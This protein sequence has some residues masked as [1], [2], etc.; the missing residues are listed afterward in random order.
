MQHSPMTRMWFSKLDPLST[1]RL[2][3]NPY[4]LQGQRPETWLES[5][6]L[7]LGPIPQL[8]KHIPFTLSCC[9]LAKQA[10]SSPSTELW[11]I[12]RIRRPSLNGQSCPTSP[13]LPLKVQSQVWVGIMG[14][15]DIE[16]WSPDQT[17][18]SHVTSTTLFISPLSRFSQL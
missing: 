16:V 10:E 13:H 14:A 18:G 4:H 3:S 7:A 5:Q 12:M 6:G 11:E 8:T 15:P 1:D 17:A 9:F 2:E